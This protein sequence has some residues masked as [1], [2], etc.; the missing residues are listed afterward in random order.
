MNPLPYFVLDSRQRSD[1]R[2]RVYIRQ[3]TKP[4]IVIPTDYFV[5][6]E[7]EFR[8]G[9][10]KD[11]VLH[12]SCSAL[13]R[14]LLDIEKKLGGASHL[15]ECWEILRQK[16]T[17]SDFVKDWVIIPMRHQITEFNAR[18]RVSDLTAEKL[19]GYLRHLKE[20]K[21]KDTTIGNHIA[22]LKRA[23]SKAKQKALDVPDDI[24]GFKPRLKQAMPKEPLNWIELMKLYNLPPDP[25]LD[26]FLLECFTGI[27]YSDLTDELVINETHILFRQKKT[28]RVAAPA[29]NPLA[30]AIIERNSVLDIDDGRRKF[31]PHRRA[32]QSINRKLK[33]IASNHGIRKNLSTHI[34]RHSYAMLLGDLGVPENIRAIQLGHSPIGNT[35]MYGRSSDY[36]F[37]SRIVLAAFRRAM[38][39]KGR[40]YEEWLMEM[41][42]MLSEVYAVAK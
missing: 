5:A 33:T 25:T 41:N 12:N 32:V 19:N 16:P 15:R 29:L 23:A 11:P 8:K 6:R 40:T 4:P 14:R 20:A 24:F 2:F 7:S 10:P 13:L 39:S 22:E 36:E 28:G 3:N 27:R 1:G 18:W 26:M 38:A 35:Q 30:K 21:L 34:G 37:A 42:P 17:M 31:V 9:W